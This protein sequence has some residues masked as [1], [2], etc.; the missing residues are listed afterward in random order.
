MGWKGGA[1]HG[2]T[3]FLKAGSRQWND[4]ASEGTHMYG[5]DK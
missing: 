4:M 5:M 2:R 1:G 3:S